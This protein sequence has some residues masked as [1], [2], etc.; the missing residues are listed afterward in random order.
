MYDMNSKERVMFAVNHKEADRI[1][2]FGPNMIDTHEPYDPSVVEFL[3]AYPFDRFASHFPLIKTPKSQKDLGDG[4]FVDGYGC[5]YKYMGVGIPYCT[6]SP[7]ANAETVADIEAFEWP[8]PD[9]PDRLRPD[10]REIA[11]ETHA[12]NDFAVTAGISTIFH[13]YQH[14]RGFEQWM[15][16]MKLN[17]GIYEA[18]V[19]RLC[20]INK[21]LVMRVLEEIGEYVDIV[22]A[23][24][25]VY[26]G[27]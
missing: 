14:L 7:L 17:P 13:Q 11:I 1:P 16:D 26:V 8:D 19:T 21:T 23:D 10:A 20:H 25:I 22:S 15:I 2:I 27:G 6:H 18:I 24:R 3:D 4:N 12:K 5:E 9:E